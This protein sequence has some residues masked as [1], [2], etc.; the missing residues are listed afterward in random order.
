MYSIDKGGLW[1]Q[2]D[3]SDSRSGCYWPWAPGKLF[4][5]SEPVFFGWLL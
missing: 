4:N 1:S 5:L 3:E 2:D